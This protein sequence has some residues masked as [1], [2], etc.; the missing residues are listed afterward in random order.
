MWTLFCDKLGCQGRMRSLWRTTRG[1]NFSKTFAFF[2]GR[3]DF[4]TP[5]FIWSIVLFSFTP[6]R[7]PSLKG[8]PVH[9]HYE[10]RQA[11]HLEPPHR[12]R[13]R[14]KHHFDCCDD[15]K[16]F[17]RGGHRLDHL[18]AGHKFGEEAFARIRGQSGARPG[19]VSRDLLEAITADLAL[20]VSAFA[21]WP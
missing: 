19:D 11:S 4:E 6:T 5:V 12:G 2:M 1:G 13:G 18:R 15:K 9:L 10:I 14:A 7:N 8:I 17:A 20:P 21:G 3:K 16:G